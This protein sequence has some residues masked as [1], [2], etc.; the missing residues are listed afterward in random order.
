VAVLQRDAARTRK[1]LL[2]A[3]EHVVTEHGP[4]FSLD[5][6]AQEAGVSKG[7]LLHHFRSRDALLVALVEAWIERFDEAVQQQLDPDDDRP[8]RVC[9]AH[10]RATFDEPEVTGG[11]WMHTSVQ[12]ALIGVP[13][14]LERARADAE[15][16]QRD[17]AG[18]GLH[19]QR[20]LLISRALDG[21]ATAELFFDS[22]G[23]DHEARR[24]LRDLLLALTEEAGPLVPPT[25]PG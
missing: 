10:I 17:M 1:A 6:V 16:W 3:A 20:V 2:A 11:A 9:R 8:G 23:V 15:R 24:E 12:T 18:D 7:G 22:A 13:A 19:P 14:V 4:A 21:E 5:A 25:A